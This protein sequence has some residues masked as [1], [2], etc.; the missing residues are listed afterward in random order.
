MAAA[1]VL[2][3]LLCLRRQQFRYRRP[4][5]SIATGGPDLVPVEKAAV[6]VGAPA[7]GDI[8]R[9]H[10][11]LRHV[12][13]T[14]IEVLD[15]AA[16]QLT[17]S[18]ITMHLA[19]AASLPQ[20]WQP[21][22]QTGMAWRFPGSAAVDEAGSDPEEIGV[23]RPFPALVHVGSDATSSWLLNLEQI[24][25]LVLTGD[26]DRCLNLARVIAAQLGLNPWA[27][28]IGV[29]LLGFG[30]ELLDAAP[31]RLRYATA[32]EAAAVVSATRGKAERTVSTMDF[33]LDV[34]QARRQASFDEVWPPHVL[35]V[36]GDLLTDGTAN[37]STDTANDSA[38]TE[39]TRAVSDLLQLVH[40]HAGLTGAAVVV[41]GGPA[42]TTNGAD[43][44][45][46]L[47]SDGTLTLPW[48]DVTLTAPGWDEDTARGV[49]MLLAHAR[50]APDEKIPD[51]TGEKPWQALSDATG[52]LRT[53]LVMP[54]ATP[55]VHDINDGA[56][57]ALPL[58]DEVYLDTS[59][60]TKEDLAALAPIVPAD[61]R[62]QVEE[63]DPSP[64]RRRR[65]LVRRHQPNPQTQ[66]S[67]TRHPSHH[68]ARQGQAALLR[69]AGRL[70]RA[71]GTRRV[72]RPDRHR[73][74]PRPRISPQ[75]H[76]HPARPPRHQPRHR[77]AVLAKRQRVQVRQGPRHEHLPADRRARRRRPVPP[78]EA[79]W[80]RSRPG[81]RQA[82]TTTS[83]PYAWS[84]ESRSHRCATRA[85]HGSST[86]TGSTITP[87]LQSSTSPTSST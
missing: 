13:A 26:Q 83:P 81:T 68:Q 87:L 31:E 42:L 33:G 82:S 48:F 64:R 15:L 17:G 39:L 56:A 2:A 7:A 72:H 63:A 20:P 59:A 52:A 12:A 22:D 10:E 40:A 47:H 57:C 45:L 76:Q 30:A 36:A 41:V 54:R 11:V 21:V 74:Q 5:R 43:A 1:G 67:R 53:E 4:G 27:D 44:T 61:V 6:T 58:A 25:G 3:A 14:D 51:A 49:G 29:T 65:R 85:G 70:P 38:G 78:A 62:A 16:V 66:R 77:S 28:C 75:V 35:L 18:T 79:A 24:G 73:V 32:T 69:R 86:A 71:P 60:S 23:D 80:R 37:T 34:V 19:R 55:Y 46:H 84:P 8:A 50:N 9:L